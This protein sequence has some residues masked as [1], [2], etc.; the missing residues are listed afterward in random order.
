[1]QVHV[2]GYLNVVDGTATNNGNTVSALDIPYHRQGLFLKVSHRAVLLG[3]W[4]VPEEV[5]A[6]PLL[7][8]SSDLR[9]RK[10]RA[11]KRAGALEP[12]VTYP[13]TG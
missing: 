12:I 3:V 5:M 4:E 2:Q 13:E 7:F 1:M 9:A 8:F 10:Q 11:H 6:D